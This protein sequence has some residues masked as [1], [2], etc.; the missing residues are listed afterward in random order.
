MRA[1]L[2]AEC[3]NRRRYLS[4]ESNIGVT[5]KVAIVALKG[6]FPETQAA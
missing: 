2:P 5:S 1:S 3:H 4:I 6:C